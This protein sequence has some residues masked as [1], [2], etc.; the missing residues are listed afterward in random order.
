MG[1]EQA[2]SIT[3][4]RLA[5]Q[6]AINFIGLHHEFGHCYNDERLF[7]TMSNCMKANEQFDPT[8]FIIKVNDKMSFHFVTFQ[9]NSVIHLAVTC[10]VKQTIYN[11]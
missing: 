7:T 6:A 2:F 10:M 3:S 5:S 8:P 4:P 11:E 9:R 1:I